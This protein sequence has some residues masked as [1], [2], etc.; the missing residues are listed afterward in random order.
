MA[1][2]HCLL[3]E[4]SLGTPCCSSHLLPA[5][6]WARI[7]AE[8]AGN[9]TARTQSSTSSTIRPCTQK[10]SIPSTLPRGASG[11]VGALH[12]EP[13]ACADTVTQSQKGSRFVAGETLVLS[14]TLARA[15]LLLSHLLP[16][17]SLL[18]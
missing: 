2:C 18:R 15:F 1:A 4:R 12:R 5:D 13:P 16:T 14:I 6:L 8:T 17:A 9:T 11:A 7:F 10:P 3:Q